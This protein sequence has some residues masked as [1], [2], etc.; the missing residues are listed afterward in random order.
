M[1]KEG[2]QLGLSF[3]GDPMKERTFAQLKDSLEAK[4]NERIEHSVFYHPH[5]MRDAIIN[6]VLF[7]RPGRAKTQ[8]D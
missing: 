7:G 4:Q 1:I 5:A 8:S 6:D 2:A 3:F